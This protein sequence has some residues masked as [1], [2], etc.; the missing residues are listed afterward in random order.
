M[1]IINPLTLK[2]Q[3]M[4]TIT[5]K[6]GILLIA[7]LFS[8]LSAMGYDFSEQNADGVMMYYNIL[9]ENDKTCAVTAME[10]RHSWYGND[11]ITDYVGDIRIPSLANGYRVTAIDENAFSSCK[12]ITSV[13]IPNTITSIGYS[14]FWNCEGIT[15]VDIPNSVTFIDG[16]AFAYCRGLTSVTIPESIT[17][18][19]YY[20]FEYC[21][22]LTTVTIPN[23]VTKIGKSAF[24]YCT[25]LESVSIPESVTVIEERA[26]EFCSSLASL[27]IPQN[28]TTIGVYAFGCCDSLTSITVPKSVTSIGNL[29]FAHNPNVVSMV[30]EEGNPNYTSGD[31]WNCIVEIGTNTLISGCQNTVIPNTVQTIGVG[32]FRGCRTLTSITIP[33]SVTRIESSA[34][35]HT[36]LASVEFSNSLEYIGN[37]AFAGCTSL[38]SITLPNSLTTIDQSAFY[39]CYNLKTVTIPSSV[40]FIGKQAFSSCSRLESVTSYITDVFET[41]ENAF[42]GVTDA[43][44][45]VPAG[46]VSTYQ[47]TA[48]WNRLNVEEIAGIS[49]KLACSDCGKVTINDTFTFSNKLCEATV[50]DGTDN[51]FVFIPEEGYQLDRVL[52][53]GLDVTRSVRN[54][55]LTAMMLPNSTMMVIFTAKNGDING[56][57]IMDIDDVSSL[58]N[59]ILGNNP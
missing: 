31:N 20:T 11:T 22:G 46:L 7:V 39:I 45:Y 34:F 41:G 23:R 32:A 40:T 1:L 19:K 56:D 49:L 12:L 6:I 50:Y 14:A 18:I 8:S 25:G 37:S 10:E 28:V 5:T 16:S 42:S 4:K 30:V 36:G 26:F 43:T 57:G 47:A 58:M 51:K 52:V 27:T 33:N 59:R 29:A 38:I 15:T 17:E 35:G 9:S 2:N 48:D 21:S 3:I 55:Q 44:L 24:L 53:N 54:N 13:T